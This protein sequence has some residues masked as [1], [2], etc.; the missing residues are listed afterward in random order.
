MKWIL[1]QIKSSSNKEFEHKIEKENYWKRESN[2]GKKV[3]I[4]KKATYQK[5]SEKLEL[6]FNI[7]EVKFHV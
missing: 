6:D 2:T 3:K 7:E 1:G 4:L 5:N